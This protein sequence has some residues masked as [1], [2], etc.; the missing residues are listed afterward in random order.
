MSKTRNSGIIGEKI[1]P[2]TDSA[3]GVHDA[4]DQY[5]AQKDN[6]WPRTKKVESVTGSFANHYEGERRYFTVVTSGFDTG[7]TIY[8]TISPGSLGDGGSSNFRNYSGSFSNQANNSNSFYI[9]PVYDNTVDGSHSYHFQIR[10]SYNGHILYES[11]EITIPDATYYLTPSANN[12]NEGGSV[13][14]TMTASNAYPATYYWTVD[15]TAGNTTDLN[16]NNNWGNFT[17]NG[18]SGAFSIS[19][20]AD[21][22][23]EGT[24]SFNVRLR[25]GSTVG[26]ILA[27][28]VIDINDTSVSASATITPSSTSQNEGS[29]VTFTVATTGIA[30]GTNIAYDTLR[31]SDMEAS[32]INPSQGAVTINNNTGSIVIVAVSDSYTETGQTESYQVRVYDSNNNV[33]ATSAVVT[34]NDTSTGTP[35]PSGI[36][37]TSSF[38]EIS[39][40]F[41]NSQTYM[42]SSAD[43][44]GPYDVGQVQ[45]D[46]TGTGR[47][48]IGV[49]VT[50]SPT[51]Y[52]D[53]P[54][55]GVQVLSGST[56]V[57]SWIFN[58]STGGSGS[59]W[60]TYTS[61]ISGTQST[62]FPVTPATASGY[63][64]S[65]IST[66]T[67]TGKF[68]FRNSTA[69]SYTGADNGI[70]NAYKLS[71]D[72][73]SNS[74][75]TVG[76]A[77]VS[78]T[79]NTYYAYRETSGST[80][81]SGAVMRS[82]AYTFSG[83][84]S[85]RVIHAL[86]GPTSYQMDPNDTLYVAVY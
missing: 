14:F 65:T 3:S 5:I 63:S 30:N 43:Y 78:Q 71:A 33:M 37:I 24:E 39:N 28:N 76:N 15:G 84:E 32:D 51:Y 56:L 67:G 19:V 25:G 52:N 7:D 54:I 34:I 36:D 45:T 46:F 42:G 74:I 29:S 17:Y 8:W 2:T 75:V 55:A 35:E 69:S 60:T 81:W 22:L 57:A 20:V 10:R 31:S 47:V 70:G 27:T 41:L 11:P 9:E 62:G 79:S 73:G 58:T 64:Y 44:N 26:A 6:A 61:Q 12:V 48:Y 21:N 86:T 16:L 1:S 77:T 4:F 83:G 13:T 53:V 40:R 85:I 68:A 82:P 38:Y 59:G 72:G 50:S 49:K 80:R 23:T 66:G 18:S